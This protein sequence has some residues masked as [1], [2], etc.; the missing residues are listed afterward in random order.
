MSVDLPEPLGPMMETN[1][2]AANGQADAAQGMD[3]ASALQVDL[4][5]LPAVPS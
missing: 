2:P 4:V 3:G 5:N 1:S